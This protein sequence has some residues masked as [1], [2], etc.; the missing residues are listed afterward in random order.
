MGRL[1]FAFFFI[2]NSRLGCVHSND[3]R[4]VIATVQEVD[5]ELHGLGI[6]CTDIFVIGAGFELNDA[7]LPLLYA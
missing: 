5:H 7:F 4:S 1:S 3:R 6:V 2:E